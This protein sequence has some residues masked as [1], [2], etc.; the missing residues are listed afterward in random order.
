MSIWRSFSIKKGRDD[1]S[2]IFE[3]HGAE[4]HLAPCKEIVGRG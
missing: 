2:R 1:K 3:N 4:D